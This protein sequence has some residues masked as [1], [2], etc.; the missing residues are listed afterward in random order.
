MPDD[1]DQPEEAIED[2]EHPGRCQPANEQGVPVRVK[3][4]VECLEPAG[5]RLGS[6][7]VE[8]VRYPDPQRADRHHERQPARDERVAGRRGREHL[9]RGDEGH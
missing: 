8:Q 7:E 5:G 3:P 2:E 9:H 1:A 4:V 6:Y